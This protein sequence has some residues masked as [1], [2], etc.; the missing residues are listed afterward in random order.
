MLSYGKGKIRKYYNRPPGEGKYTGV[1]C[2]VVA[3]PQCEIIGIIPIPHT[4][5]TWNHGND[6]S[7]ISGNF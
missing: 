4:T 3:V 7:Y 6:T 5:Q 2:R 1:S